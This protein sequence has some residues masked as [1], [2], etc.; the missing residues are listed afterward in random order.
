MSA[1]S[2]ATGHSPTERTYPPGAWA[3]VDAADPGLVTIVEERS[4]SARRLIRTDAPR[5]IGH[6][7]RF[8]IL[9]AAWFW[10]RSVDPSREIAFTWSELAD[11]LGNRRP[12]ATMSD[13]LRFAV[14]QLCAPS[15]R[16]TLSSSLPTEPVAPF[17]VARRI[18]RRG[19]GQHHP[20]EPGSIISV[21]PLLTPLL[22]RGAF[23]SVTLDWQRRASGE[24]VRR[25]ALY[26]TLATLRPVDADGVI[27]ARLAA[28]PLLRVL[29]VDDSRADRRAR[30]LAEAVA[31]LAE[32]DPRFA[33]SDGTTS[34]GEILLVRTQPLVARP[35][36]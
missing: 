4:G 32:R 30:R 8:A 29:G 21:D 10:S 16:A 1:L 34:G 23:A 15:V 7:S 12:S 5:A 31:E 22:E 27:R 26:A 18:H 24:L 6:W 9:S 28:E 20:T 14:D 13:R 35:E 17:F 25:L 36:L 19:D 2:I 33:G 3:L 11:A